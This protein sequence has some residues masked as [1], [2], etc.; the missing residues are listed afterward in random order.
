MCKSYF[1][2]LVV[3]FIK[4]FKCFFPLTGLCQK[5]WIYLTKYLD[6]LICILW[7]LNMTTAWKTSSTL[8]DSVYKLYFLRFVNILLSLF[9]IFFT[10][11]LFFHGVKLLHIKGFP[12]NYLQVINIKTVWLIS[13]HLYYFYVSYWWIELDQ[14]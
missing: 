10:W 5:L 6:Y 7:A 8:D 14:Y 12:A 9:Y 3:R 4:L 2:F 13:I 11:I 1:V